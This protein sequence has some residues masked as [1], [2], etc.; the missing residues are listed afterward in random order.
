VD[1]V[2]PDLHLG[3]HD[4]GA[5]R[6]VLRAYKALRP[7]RVVILGDWLD[8]H[9]W[10]SHPLTPGER[11]AHYLNDEVEPCKLILDQFASATIVYHEGNHEERVRRRLAEGRVPSDVEDLILPE[12][13]LARDNL[14][15]VPYRH[16]YELLP[17]WVTCHGVSEA[18]DASRKHLDAYPGYSV[19]FG[20][21]HRAQHVIRRD[22]VTGRHLHG[23]CPGTLSELQPVWAKGPTTWSHGFAVIQKGVPFL[24]PIQDGKATL[25]NGKR[26]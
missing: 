23:L 17:G 3:H 18:K 7:D 24:V 14:T 12:K 8:A 9:S 11:R 26:I 16:H 20:H 22:P 4:R 15:W 1:L 19:V 10:S 21:T 5:L 2:L 6:C 25:P 13:L